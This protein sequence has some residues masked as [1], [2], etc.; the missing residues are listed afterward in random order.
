MAQKFMMAAFCLLFSTGALYAQNV[1]ETLEQA[2]QLEKQMKE[3]EALAKYKDVLKAQPAQLEALIGAS[4]LS[5][6]EGNRQKEK[7]DKTRYFNEAKEYA[8]E[9]LKAA[10]NDANANYAMAVAMG[11]LALISGAKE[12]VAASR[13]VKKYAELA[14]KFNPNYGQAYH[15]LGKWNYEVANLSFLEKNAAKALFGGLPDGSMDQAIA[16]Y[17][18][19]RKLDPGFILNYYE[20]ARAYNKNDQQTLAMD[21][22]RKAVAL[23]PVTQDDP[24]IKA[25][26]KKMLEE[27]Q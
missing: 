21:V 8:A 24:G 27:L 3:A 18:K 6:R 14:I 16:N 7:E 25:E 17:E 4:E 15:V 19:C 13:D 22:L 11:R 26:C 2:K 20:L 5:S 1:D 10:P 9:A 23:R 12:K